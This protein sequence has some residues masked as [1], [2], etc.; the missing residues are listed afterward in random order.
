MGDPDFL[1]LLEVWD[2]RLAEDGFDDIE[3]R[4]KLGGQEGRLLAG[5]SPSSGDLRRALYNEE[6][7]DYYR[8]ARQHVWEMKRGPRRHVW[9]LHSDGVPYQKIARWLKPFYDLSERVVGRI[10]SEERKKMLEA[11]NGELDRRG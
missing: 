4:S 1:A 6:K 10:V 7:E 8:L 5:S 11:V 2:K 3:Q 9:R